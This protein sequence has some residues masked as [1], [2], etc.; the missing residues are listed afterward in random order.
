MKEIKAPD[1]SY[2]RLF[3]ESPNS[4]VMF[5]AGSIEMGKAVNW[6][7]QVVEAFKEDENV[8]FLNPRRDD[9]DSSWE[10][11]IKNKKF[12]E[13]VEWELDALD[14]C[15][16]ILL[17]LDPKT[18]SPISLL[19]LGLH[20]TNRTR[21]Q[22]IVCCPEGFWRKGNVDIVCKRYGIKEVET[23]QDLIKEAKKRISDDNA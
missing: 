10:Q 14:F 13:Q 8:L 1:K 5:L 17:Y 7:K 16:I 15:D 21:P 9:W 23:I 3:Q 19:E 22:M 12:R 4:Y 18:K 20:A 2:I 6:Q 11:S